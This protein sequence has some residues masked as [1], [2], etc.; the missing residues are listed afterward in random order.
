MI[1]ILVTVT[2]CCFTPSTLYIMMSC[3]ARNV[4]SL[5]YVHTGP[6]HKQYQSLVS[7][8]VRL[9]YVGMTPAQ[10]ITIGHTQTSTSDLSVQVQKIGVDVFQRVRPRCQRTAPT[11][12]TSQDAG[13][14]TKYLTLAKKFA[15]CGFHRFGSN[16]DKPSFVIK[17]FQVPVSPP[18]CCQNWQVLQLVG[19]ATNL[20]C[21]KWPHP[22]IGE[23]WYSQ[24]FVLGCQLLQRLKLNEK[25]NKRVTVDFR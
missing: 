14:Q 2:S 16:N 12:E 21:K 4:A 25:R 22:L 6:K 20:E 13:L 18:I 7:P 5:C 23:I 24:K 8:D 10:R 15:E 11:C 1:S 3:V 19:T 9:P 17:L